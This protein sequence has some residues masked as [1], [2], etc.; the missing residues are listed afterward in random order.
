MH[1]LDDGTLRRIVDEPLSVSTA[2]QRH[3]GHCSQCRARCESIRGEARFVSDVLRGTGDVADAH[4]AYAR[5]LRLSATSSPKRALTLR[6]RWADFYLA[7]GRTYAAPV[8]A[9]L[10]AAAAV[11]LLAFTPIGTLA[12]SFLTI[13]EPKQ[14]VAIDVSKGELQYLPDLQSFGTMIQHG[15]PAHREVANPMQAARLSGLPVRLPTWIPPSVPRTV[16][17][18]VA[19]RATASFRFSAAKAQA[20]AASA[21]QTV[22]PMPPGMDGSVLGLQV[23][24]MVV[25]VYGAMPR[26]TQSSQRAGHGDDGGD[27]GDLPALAIVESAAPRVSSSGAS[28][29]DIETYLLQMPGVS[30]QLADEIRAIGDP[31]TTMPI[32]VPVDKAYSQNVTVD[33]TAG[34]AVGDNTGVGGMIVWQKN[35]IVY[36]VGGA[37]PQRQLMEVAQSLR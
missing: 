2:A 6:D 20:F 4:G 9:T 1:H 34:L 23:G 22:P 25:I 19:A 36:G 15:A 26:S 37:L 11:L 17:Y 27:V 33:G 5:F 24:P 18:T 30:P 3:V 7:R 14:F 21:H 16:H 32:P 28:A 10:A 35:G 29:R 13:F 31:S 12:Q 8:G